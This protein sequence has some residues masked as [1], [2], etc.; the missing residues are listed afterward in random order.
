MVLRAG[1]WRVR[2][3]NLFRDHWF[4]LASSPLNVL[5]VL[6]LCDK[7]SFIHTFVVLC[8]Q[9][10][11]QK[12]QETSWRPVKSSSWIFLHLF[13]WKVN[14]IR[15]SLTP[16]SGDVPAHCL[17]QSGIMVLMACALRWSSRC[18]TSRDWRRQGFLHVIWSWQENLFL[19]ERE[20][21][22][23]LRRR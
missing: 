9:N 23:R 11:K 22:D 13:L 7:S 10:F 5:L 2:K 1:K 8:E 19:T 12:W 14:I 15:R 3:W 17:M 20:K 4:S 18:L 21:M 6:S 16:W